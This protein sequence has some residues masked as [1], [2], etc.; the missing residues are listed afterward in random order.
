MVRNPHVYKKAQEEMDSV[1]GPDRLPD[2]ADRDALPYLNAIVEELYRWQPGVPLGEL[3]HAPTPGGSADDG[4]ECY[5]TPALPDVQR[6]VPQLRRSWRVHGYAEHLVRSRRLWRRPQGS[7]S[8]RG[9]SRDPAYYPEPD[10]FRPE[11]HLDRD[12]QHELPSGFVFGFGRRSAF[13]STVS[14]L[15]MMN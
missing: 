14:R 11:R 10:E 2:F 6:Q 8:C 13:L 15:S 5:S 9:M 7:D 1:V 4:S 3:L 12:G